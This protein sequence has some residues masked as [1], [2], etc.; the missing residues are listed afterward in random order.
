LKKILILIVILLLL[1]SCSEENTTAPETV[2]TFFRAES[3]KVELMHIYITY[4]N[5]W[6]WQLTA[7]YQYELKGSSGKIHTHTFY[8]EEI[9]TDIVK[10]DMQIADCSEP[11]DVELNKYLTGMILDDLFAGFD[12]VTVYFSLTGVFQECSGGSADSIS[13][14]TWS[15]TIRA[16]VI[17]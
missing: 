3:L 15:D 2:D 6:A 14:I 12:S 10:E 11:I 8:F 1:G 4:L 5:V 17:D 16:D 9:D 7:T 13:V